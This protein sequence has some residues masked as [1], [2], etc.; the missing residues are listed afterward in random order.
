MSG[1]PMAPLLADLHRAFWQP[2]GEALPEGTREVIFCPDE[3]LHLLPFA[4]LRGADGR[5]LCETM[6]ARRVEDSGRV[7]AAGARPK[8]DFSKPWLALGIADFAAHRGLLEKRDSPWSGALANLGELPTVRRELADLRQLAPEGST[9]LLDRAAD[10]AALHKA[11]SPAVLHVASH[12]F[13]VALAGGGDLS[14]DPSALYESGLLLSPGGD[15]D[16]ILFPEEAGALDLRGTGL[17]TLSICRGALG[18]PVAGEGVLGLR[19]AFAKAG[20]RHVLA[21]LW[22]IPDR[23]TA[24]FMTK[25]YGS[26]SSAKYPAS[27]LWSM[28]AA[29]LGRLHG[30]NPAGAAV[31]TSILSYGGFTVSATE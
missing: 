27:L 7:L 14:A 23:S 1:I 29:E 16:G 3:K 21:S 19:R 2:V 31:E 20:A 26:L 18:R 22:E 8:P 6:P 4:V 10:E 24:A 9:I 25:Y 30:E 28:Q 15:D 13:H 12:G 5:F 17:V 11:A